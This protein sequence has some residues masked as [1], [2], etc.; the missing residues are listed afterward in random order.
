MKNSREARWRANGKRERVEKKAIEI[1]A[2]VT[3]IIV[4]RSLRYLVIL[5]A[6]LRY[7]TS[8]IRIHLYIYIY[9]PEHSNVSCTC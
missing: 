4:L 1:R 9:I 6:L 5:H 3:I 8:S 7:F 2:L